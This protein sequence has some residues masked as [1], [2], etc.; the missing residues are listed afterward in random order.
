[1]WTILATL[2]LV[3]A[4]VCGVAGIIDLALVCLGMSAA[5]LLFAAQQVREDD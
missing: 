2:Q 1:M 5:A 4:A 3:A